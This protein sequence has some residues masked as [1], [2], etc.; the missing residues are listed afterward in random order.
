MDDATMAAKQ[1]NNTI[2][3]LDY[4]MTVK[5]SVEVADAQEAS[6]KKQKHVKQETVKAPMKDAPPLPPGTPGGSNGTIATTQ[7]TEELYLSS[8]KKTA[9]VILRNLS[10]YATEY[11]IRQTMKEF[12]EIVDIN[13]PLV[14][15]PKID[16]DDNDIGNDDSPFKK[17]KKKVNQQHRGFAFVTFAN[18]KSA[19]DA[20]QQCSS[21]TKQIIIK[22]RPV[23]IDFSV[24]KVQHNRIKE[25]QAHEKKN[26][27]Q[28]KEDSSSTG[29][30]SDSGSD[31]ESGS[32]SG[33]DSESGSD[34]ESDSEES[35]DDEDNDTK[36]TKSPPPHDNNSHSHSLFLRNLPFDATRQDLFLLFK[37]FGYIDGIFLVKD[38]DTGICRG[39]AFVKFQK[40]GGCAR[41][42]QACSNSDTP[43]GAAAG[44]QSGKDMTADSTT[45][46]SAGGLFLHGRRILVDLA[47]DKSTADTLKVERDED[48][49]PIGQKIGK[50]RRNMYLK[51]E[52]RV[53]KVEDGGTDNDAWENLTESDQQKRGRAHQEKHTKLRSPLFFINPFRLS[54]RNLSK[55]LD[56]SQLKELMVKGIQQ[57]LHNG[58]V[59]KDDLIAHWRAGGE[60]TAREIME[61]VA[62]AERKGDVVPSYDEKKGIKNYIPS[63]FIDRDFGADGKG[64]KNTAP[65]R[66]FGFVEFTHHA[67][68][69]ACLRELNNNSTYSSDYVAGGK[70]AIAL[71]RNK[72]KKRQKSQM[73]IDDGA[74]PEDFIGEDGKVRIPRLIVEFTV[75]N[76][77][78]ARKQA[79]R[80]AQQQANVVKQKAELKEQRKSE[81]GAELK[82]KKKK[83]SRGAQQREKKRKMREEG[84]NGSSTENKTEKVVKKQKFEEKRD[85]P[86]MRRDVKLKGVKPSKKKK[87]NDDAVGEKTFEDMVRNYK[88]TFAGGIKGSTKTGEIEKMTENPRKDVTK[89]RWFN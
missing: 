76:K 40:E 45:N 64:H 16:S 77:A 17:K 52:G 54:I 31:S 80:K 12:G 67:H 85:V 19:H 56:E 35:E 5:V 79:E 32:D 25:E 50:D 30:D 27:D 61:K 69:L 13:L 71:K 49:K 78:K 29:S 2:M 4:G 51:G 81:T 72:K 26:V 46:S 6:T 58:L 63:V 21:S 86:E 39:T 84:G 10:F 47:V 53:E 34:E 24:A 3:K 82:R 55:S 41:A 20:V 7:T 14:P 8:K 38:K 43:G 23:A 59:T 1:L 11:H 57:G 37:Q 89:K 33:S 28:E 70:K 74:A 22:K 73:N 87:M 9:R 65:S 60:M 66:G 15:Q 68:A 48:G 42:L 36:D 18:P 83:K 44:F 75:E 62:T 88:E